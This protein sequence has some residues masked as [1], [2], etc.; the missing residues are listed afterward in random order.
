MSRLFRRISNP[1]NKTNKMKK[2]SVEH[3]TH[4]QARIEY[5][6]FGQDTAVA[7]CFAMI[8]VADATLT[9]EQQLESVRAAYFHL[10]NLLP[11]GNH[12]SKLSPSGELEGGYA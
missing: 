3:I 9:F 1:T 7:E 8:H 12:N 4:G 11:D 2:M 5:T 6:I 10:I